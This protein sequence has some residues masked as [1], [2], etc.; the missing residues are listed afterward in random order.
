M[1]QQVLRELDKLLQAGVLDD[2]AAQRIRDHY[3]LQSGDSQ[4]RLLMVFGIL[5][6]L[7][8]GLGISLMVAH[9]WDNLSRPAKTFWAFLPLLIGQAACV[10]AKF[11]RADSPAWREGAATFLVFAVGA[12]IA[13]VSQIY[14]IPGELDDF[15][16]SWSLLAAPL[17]YVMPSSMTSL[18][19]ITGITWYG[20][21]AGYFKYPKEE[22][23]AYWLL[24]AAVIPHYAALLRKSPRSNFSAFHHV[25]IAASLTIMLGSLARGQYHWIFPAYMSMLGLMYVAG[26]RLAKAG[27]ALLNGYTLAGAG[28][29]LMLL[30]FFSFH[31]VWKGISGDAAQHSAFMQAPEFYVMS[32][33]SLALALMMLPVF[34]KKAAVAS[35]LP[36][37][38]AALLFAVVFPLGL[39]SPWLAVLIVNLMVLLSG[40]LLTLQGERQNHLGLMNLGLLT[41]TALIVCRFFDMDL[42]YIERG[43]MFLLAGAGFFMMNARLLRKKKQSL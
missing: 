9:N 24:L 21:E 33:I 40:L 38:A 19:F 35:V 15:L 3:A 14:H 30:L 10:F 1:S 26:M 4:N 29:V 5:G 6:A 17:I 42:S 31:D 39:S 36:F 41:I 8:A 16:L 13:M 34:R 43:L 27:G 11:K 18:L 32:A 23:Y 12:C 25:L 28:G 20:C 7:L 37:G 2:A 22:P